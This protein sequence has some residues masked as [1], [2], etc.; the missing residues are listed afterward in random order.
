M[1]RF[2]F[3]SALVILPSFAR[4]DAVSDAD[5]RFK[6]G[7]ALQHQGKVES[8]REKYLQSLALHRSA[9]TLINLAV[10]EADANRPDVAL[11][12]LR[13]W[14]KHPGIDPTKKADVEKQMLPVLERETG[15]VQVKA[16]AGQDVT[17]DGASRGNAPIKDA[18][19]LLPGAHR[20][21]CGAKVVEV[22]LRAGETLTVDVTEAPTGKPAGPETTKG[23]W[24]L[25]ATLGGIGVLGVGVGVVLG[26]VSSAA[27]SDA[28]K[29]G[30][31][32][33]CTNAADPRCVD[34]RSSTD[35]ANGTGT[36]AIVSYVV[37]GAFLGS[38]LIT[39]LV[40]QP[41]KERPRKIS[42]MP[43]LGGVVAVGTF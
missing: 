8:A 32:V 26:V 15:R 19:D 4:A 27:K 22:T 33:V 30:A 3:V 9:S 25:P 5:L 17:V 18:V 34:V 16:P 39:A 21:A 10:L 38:A 2:V 12:Y 11:K 41:W 40:T 37:G 42:V 1:K 29:A 28:E 23:D 24:L 7:V 20:V 36:G 31:G 13:E 6:E 14:L 43:T 35:T